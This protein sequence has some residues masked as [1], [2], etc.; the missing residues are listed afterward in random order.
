MRELLTKRL[1]MPSD[2]I[3]GDMI[4]TLMENRE[5]IIENY[6][7][8]I[9]YQSNCVVVKGKNSTLKLTGTQLTIQYFTNEDM[10]VEG[11]IEYIQYIN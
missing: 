11:N 2:V 1:Q 10:R 8:L 5:A 6:K 3:S 4:V 7:G 9:T